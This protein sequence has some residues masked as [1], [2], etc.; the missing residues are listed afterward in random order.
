MSILRPVVTFLCSLFKSRRQ[1][2]LE[3]LALKQ[4]VAM[5]YNPRP[6]LD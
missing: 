6:W 5:S 4:Q 3:N 1:L 2:L